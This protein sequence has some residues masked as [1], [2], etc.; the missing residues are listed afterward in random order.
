MSLLSR[1]GLR[2]PPKQIPIKDVRALGVRIGE[3]CR[4][5]VGVDFGSEPYLVSIGNHVTL[6]SGV[7][8]VTHDGGVW[9]FREEFPEID[10]FAPVKIG[11]NVFVGYNAILLPGTEIGDQC[12]IG[13]GAVVTGYI[14]PG[15]VA[16]G[17]PAKVITTV[18]EYK[19]RALERASHIRNKSPEEKRR[20]LLQR[21]ASPPDG[22]P[23]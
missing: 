14:P 2:P 10:L 12:I 23:A 4:I 22:P 21:F 17:I 19:A 7:R 16:V 3:D 9:V 8:I 11:N 15:S 6:T 13:A 1:L 18:E 20:I 5:Y